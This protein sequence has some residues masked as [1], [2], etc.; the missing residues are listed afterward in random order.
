MGRP[1][2]TRKSHITCPK[3]SLSHE[4]E[5]EPWNPN[6]GSAPVVSATVMPSRA[7]STGHYAA[8]CLSLA[9]E[10]M[11]Q[12]FGVPLYIPGFVLCHLL[13]LDMHQ[14]V[15]YQPKTWKML[16]PEQTL[17]YAHSI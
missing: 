17:S 8:E 4:V 2:C 16:S 12:M 14:I 5:F 15:D 10:A 1:G 11:D 7:V 6:L 9:S 3:P 13:V